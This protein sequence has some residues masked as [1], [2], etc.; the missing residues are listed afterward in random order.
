MG[1]H[2][3]VGCNGGLFKNDTL[4]KYK[5]TFILDNTGQCYSLNHKFFNIKTCSFSML[6]QIPAYDFNTE[7]LVTFSA[8]LLFLTIWN[9]VYRFMYYLLREYTC[10]TEKLNSQ[11]II[12]V[13]FYIEKSVQGLGLIKMS[14]NLVTL[15]F[16]LP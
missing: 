9:I 5:L 15:I 13:H 1:H 11:L 6:F 4:Y 2:L 12:S 3:L 8:F 10:S 14:Q 7:F 16:R